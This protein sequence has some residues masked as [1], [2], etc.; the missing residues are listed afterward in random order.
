M[1]TTYF[2]FF[3]T[4]IHLEFKPSFSACHEKIFVSL[5]TAEKPWTLTQRGKMEMWD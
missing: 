2:N 5:I 1:N 3:I 4:S